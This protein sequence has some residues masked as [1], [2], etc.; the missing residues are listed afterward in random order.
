M[1]KIIYVMLNDIARVQPRILPW[2][3]LVLQGG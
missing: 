1:L 3:G 2:T